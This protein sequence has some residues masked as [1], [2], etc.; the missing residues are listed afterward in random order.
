MVHGPAGGY[1]EECGNTTSGLSMS[2][3]AFDNLTVVFRTSEE[4]KGGG[5]EMYGLCFKQAEAS[6]PSKL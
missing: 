6:L 1:Y 2:Q 3:L 4:V 5:F